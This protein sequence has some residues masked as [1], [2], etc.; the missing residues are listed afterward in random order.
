[1]TERLFDKDS[2]L[3][4][5]EAKVLS[6]K[7]IEKEKFA[8]ILDRTAFFYD[9]G[10]QECDKGQIGYANVLSVVEDGHDI[11]HIVDKPLECEKTVFAKIDWTRRFDFMQ[12]HS[13]EHIVSG[14]ANSLYSCENV[15]FHLRENIVT[16]DFDKPLNQEQISKIEEL[17]N[18]KVFENVKFRAYY[19]EDSVLINLKYRSKKEIDGKIRIVEIENTDMCACCAPHVNYSGEIGLIKLTIQERIRQGVRLE[20][21][22]GSRL[23]AD[24]NEKYENIHKISNLLCVK[25]QDTASAVEKL[26]DQISELKFKNTGL[27]KKI[28]LGKSDSF[29]SSNKIDFLFEEELEIKE[30]QVFS[31]ALYKKYGG[32]KGVFSPCDSGFYFAICGATQELNEFFVEFKQRFSVKGGGNNGMVQGTVLCDNEESL[33]L[34]ASEYK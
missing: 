25:Q 17:A 18:Q 5:F 1:M 31:D 16:L 11:V 3:K 34:F 2:H 28:I 32:I 33:K 20:L 4:E 26:I 8:V 9:G 12:Q 21:K 30:L 27:K 13:A 29:D 19:P 6:C 14:V 7:Q 15:G 24:Y 22:A 23:L 10:G